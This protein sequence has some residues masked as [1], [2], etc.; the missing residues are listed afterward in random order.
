MTEPTGLGTNLGSWPRRPDHRVVICMPSARPIAPEVA[1]SFAALYGRGLVGGYVTAKIIHGDTYIDTARNLLVTL[2]IDVPTEPTHIFWFDDDQVIPTDAIE[3]L[4]AH[5][6]PIVGGLYHQRVAP[7]RP[8]AY[9]AT[10][11]R[12]V[13]LIDLPD[14]PAGLVEVDGMGLGCCLVRLPIYT[15]MWERFGDVRWHRV[16]DGVGEDITFFQRVREM[17]IPIWLDC[18][19]RVGHVTRQTIDTVH[20]ESYRKASGGVYPAPA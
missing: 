18:D 10:E 3:R 16:E 19:L 20:Y 17:G 9:R 11:G 8:V 6:L 4:L 13:E 12:A 7:Y 5:D 2:A 14:N 1:D 15:A